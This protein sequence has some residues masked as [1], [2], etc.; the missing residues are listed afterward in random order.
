MEGSPTGGTP[1]GEGPRRPDPDAGRRL[2]PERQPGDAP[3]QGPVTPEQLREVI[4]EI[5][6]EMLDY[7][8]KTTEALMTAF[9][10]QANLDR[11][12]F[13][14]QMREERAEHRDEM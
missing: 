8:E 14:T 7:I 9:A 3:E 11:Q 6:A 4:A 5:R 10:V 2:G 12:A 1:P 13:A